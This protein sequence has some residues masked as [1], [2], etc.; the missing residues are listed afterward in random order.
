VNIDQQMFD[1]ISAR[2]REKEILEAHWQTKIH[3]S[4][5]GANY[6]NQNNLKVEKNRRA[7]R[8][9]SRTRSAQVK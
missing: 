3:I 9:R 7:E 1:E 2:E 5:Q 6:N 8:T 4:E